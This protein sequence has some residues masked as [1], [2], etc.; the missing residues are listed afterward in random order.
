LAQH[1]LYRD[2]ISLGDL[3][4]WPGKVICQTG[5]ITDDEKAFAIRIQPACAEQVSVFWS[6]KIVNS[7]SSQ[8]IGM[9]ANHA[10]GLVEKQRNGF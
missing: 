1:R 4:V 6:N 9:G 3:V 10:F 2:F 7:L 5:I 8:F